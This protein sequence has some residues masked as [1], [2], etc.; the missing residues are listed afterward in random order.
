MTQASATLT[1]L[2]NSS[3]QYTVE[4]ANSRAA[5]GLTDGST[6][7][8]TSY[9]DLHEGLSDMVESGCLTEQSIPDDYQWLADSLAHLA[10]RPDPQATLDR[11]H[12][13]LDRAEWDSDT[14][15]E[16]QA[17]LQQA[18]YTIHDISDEE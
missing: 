5:A 3:T 8:A 16:V 10:N 2:G 6:Q 13:A 1:S 4:E 15:T 7:I 18:E 9:T 17:C 14:L 12:A 11:I